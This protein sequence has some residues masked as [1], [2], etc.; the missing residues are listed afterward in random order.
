MSIIEQLSNDSSSMVY[1]ILRITNMLGSCV[2]VMFIGYL[3]GFHL[4]ITSLNVTTIE[5]KFSHDIEKYSR[6]SLIKNF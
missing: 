2:A 6:G 1:S 5:Y 4:Y 3:F